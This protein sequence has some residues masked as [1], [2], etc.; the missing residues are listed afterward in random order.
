MYKKLE[1]YKLVGYCYADYARDR[2]DIKS[3]TGSCQFMGDNIISWSDK[4]QSNIALSTAEAKYI[5]AASCST[6]ILWM[7][8]QL[9]DCQLKRV[10][11]LSYVI[12]LFL[13]ICLGI[14]SYT[15]GLSTLR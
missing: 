4:R 9:E 7:K 5:G 8:S 10:T 12:I 2:L 6:Q 1:D 3:T 11:F 13:S 14:P 15:L